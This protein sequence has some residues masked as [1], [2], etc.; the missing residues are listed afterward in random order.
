MGIDSLKVPRHIAATEGVQKTDSIGVA[1]CLHIHRNRL[2]IFVWIKKI[3]IHNSFMEKCVRIVKKGQDDGNTAYWLSLSEKERMSEL[4]KIRQK[5]NL[6]NY[7][8]RPKLQRVY[9]IVKRK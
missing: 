5:I 2:L 3:R 9:R 6:L 7:G 4:E 8:P 1:G